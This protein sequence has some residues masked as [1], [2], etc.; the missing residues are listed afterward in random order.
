MGEIKPYSSQRLVCMRTHN[1]SLVGFSGTSNGSRI[2]YKQRIRDPQVA[3]PGF[4]KAG[5][6]R[7]GSRRRR[8]G[9]D[10]VSGKNVS[11]PTLGRTWRGGLCPLSRKLF[12][13]FI[14]KVLFGY[15][16]FLKFIFLSLRAI[17]LRARRLA[18][19]YDLR[20]I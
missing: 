17:F 9:E 18:S 14:S 19:C 13:L 15:D 5:G 16:V 2:W 6:D 10:G 12:K 7:R 3:D 4:S 8:R 20:T 11:F 1:N